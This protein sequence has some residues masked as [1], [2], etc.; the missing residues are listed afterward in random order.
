MTV[1]QPPVLDSPLSSL[2][3]WNSDVANAINTTDARLK[4]FIAGGKITVTDSELTSGIITTDKIAANSISTMYKSRISNMA[5]G[6]DWN[7]TDPVPTSW[8]YFEWQLPIR[9]QLYNVFIVYGWDVNASG[10]ASDN[11]AYYFRYATQGTYITNWKG[12]IP[13]V[14]KGAINP[15]SHTAVFGTGYGAFGLLGGQTYKTSVNI[16]ENTTG[17]TLTNNREAFINVI[18]RAR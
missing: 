4:D 11:M 17:G 8:D 9:A 13:I 10:G 5:N 12:Q 1:N 16:Y 2:N 6:A 3:D 14:G 15:G 7:V 18:A